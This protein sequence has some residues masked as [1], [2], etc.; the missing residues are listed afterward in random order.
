[1]CGKVARLPAVLR[2]ELCVG[3]QVASHGPL[4]E[5]LLRCLSGRLRPECRWYGFP[6]APTRSCLCFVFR[7]PRKMRQP[8][9]Q[10]QST[11]KTSRCARQSLSSQLELQQRDLSVPVGMAYSAAGMAGG[12]FAAGGAAAAVGG[13]AAGGGALCGCTQE[14][15]PVM[16]WTGQGGGDYI[17]DLPWPSPLA[18]PP[19]IPCLPPRPT[20]EGVSAAGGRESLWERGGRGG[21]GCWGWRRRWSVP[22]GG[23]KEGGRGGV[24]RGGG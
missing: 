23:M 6:L 10:R 8:W 12:G 24:G 20:L 15:A 2:P 17:Q 22:G 7:Y 18:P 21:G 5:A 1:M 11:A 3:Q 4:G 13:G 16:S 9:Q 19:S 14:G